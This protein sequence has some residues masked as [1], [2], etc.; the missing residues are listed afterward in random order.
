MGVGNFAQRLVHTIG[1]HNPGLNLIKDA[2]ARIESGLA[3]VGAEQIGT[4]AVNS[5]DT[6]RLNSGAQ[7]LPEIIV[8]LAGAIL[9]RIADTLAHLAGGL[10]GESD[11]QNRVGR[12]TVGA[13]QAH[14]PLDKDA[15]FAATG[16]GRDHQATGGVDGAMLVVIILELFR[17]IKAGM[18]KELTM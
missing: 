4:E 16:T 3:G 8:G 7:M 11:R 12:D 5:A 15:G 10:L 18:P 1:E 14:V 13:D 9:N 17:F 2:K 6:G